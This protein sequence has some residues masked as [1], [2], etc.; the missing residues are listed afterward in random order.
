MRLGALNFLC[1][2]S[3]DS[4]QTGWMPRLK[5]LGSKPKWLML[6][7]CDTVLVYIYTNSISLKFC[8]F[9]GAVLRETVF[10][11]SDKV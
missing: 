8:N 3:E 9:I 10:R 11:V 5:S 7:C 4:D 1:V 6:P 2:E